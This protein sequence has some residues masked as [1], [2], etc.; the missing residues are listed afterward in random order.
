M[1]L[2]RKPQLCGGVWPAGLLWSLTVSGPHSRNQ[3]CWALGRYLCS[4]R[5]KQS[6]K[7]LTWTASYSDYTEGYSRSRPWYSH[8]IWKDK[9]KAKGAEYPLAPRDGAICLVETCSAGAFK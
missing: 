3:P 6:W 9:Q 5:K 7:W 8:G 2:P 4:I 1:F